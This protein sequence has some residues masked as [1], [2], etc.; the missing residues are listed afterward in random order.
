MRRA[1]VLLL[2]IS[3]CSS[4][5]AP[6]ASGPTWPSDA[7]AVRAFLDAGTYKAWP[8]E[9][10]VHISDGPH[11]VN[12]RVYLSPELD[13]SLKAKNLEHPKGIAAVKEIYGSAGKDTVIG[14]AYM[15]KTDA[16]SSAGANWYWYEV[17]DK[18]VGTVT[19]GKSLSPCK[20]CHMSGADLVLSTHPLR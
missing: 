14:W 3:A 12:V 15:T 6:V 18:A 4:D 10:V 7:A 9:S 1:L 20:G 2:A 13:A 19:E 17:L 5:P 11:N 8:R 16:K